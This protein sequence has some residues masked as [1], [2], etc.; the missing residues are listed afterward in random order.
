MEIFLS[1]VFL[2]GKQIEIFDISSLKDIL[3]AI[4]LDNISINQL[5]YIFIILCIH[6]YTMIS[7]TRPTNIHQDSR[8][9]IV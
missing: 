8:H 9:M 1:N 4:H 3:K 7:K 2:M 6:G 5:A